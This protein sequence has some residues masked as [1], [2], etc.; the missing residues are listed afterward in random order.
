MPYLKSARLW[1]RR[2][3]GHWI[4]KTLIL[5]HVVSILIFFGIVVTRVIG[6]LTISNDLLIGVL[7][8]YLSVFAI[9][10]SIRRNYGSQNMMKNL[11]ALSD[12]QWEAYKAVREGFSSVNEIENYVQSLYNVNRAKIFSEI[13]SLVKREFLRRD[14][15]SG[16]YVLTGKPL[17][18]KATMGI[19]TQQ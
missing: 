4:P 2:S 6:V 19:K 15:A 8:I 5:L 18:R 16:R 14:D 9:L 17:I 12:I 7:G 11:F 1:I 3:F 13:A 10:E